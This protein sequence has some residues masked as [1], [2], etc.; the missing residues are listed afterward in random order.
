MG[1]QTAQL[2]NPFRKNKPEMKKFR[3][4]EQKFSYLCEEHL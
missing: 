3:P 4:K 2:G 1:T